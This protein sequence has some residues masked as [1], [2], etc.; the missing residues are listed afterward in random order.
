VN[1]RN[2]AARGT[3]NLRIP[4][5]GT[6]AEVIGE[7]RGIAITGKTFSDEF[8]PYEVHLYK[9]RANGMEQ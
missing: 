2:K 6:T 9:V 7:S 5:N 1:L 4:A 3:F 8:K